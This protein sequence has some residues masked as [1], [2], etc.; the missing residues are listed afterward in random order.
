MPYVK[1]SECGVTNFVLAA[2]SKAAPC[3]NCDAPVPIPRKRTFDPA[4]HNTVPSS[5]PQRQ[6][7]GQP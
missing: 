3:P 1:C 6:P 5:P 2:W 7:A 4:K